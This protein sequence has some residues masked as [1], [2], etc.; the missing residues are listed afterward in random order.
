MFHYNPIPTT[1]VENPNDLRFVEVASVKE[2][3]EKCDKEKSIQCESFNYC[4]AKRLCYLAKT[5]TVEGYIPIDSSQV[6]STCDHYSRKYLFD[7]KYTDSKELALNAE[8][9]LVGSSLDDCS[10]ECVTADGFS[11]KSFEFCKT[12]NGGSV[13][14]LNSADTHIVSPETQYEFGYCA[15]Y[16]RKFCF[17]NI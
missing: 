2:C 10:K 16:K 17:F 5:H 11:C 15:H 13:C 8:V 3:A 6:A 1:T 7:F 14:L 9:K 12:D 4:S